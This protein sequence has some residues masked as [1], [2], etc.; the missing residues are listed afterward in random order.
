MRIAFFAD[1]PDQHDEP[2]LAVDVV[3]QS[4]QA[5]RADRAEHGERHAEQDDERQQ[6]A[7]VLRRERQVDEQQAEPEDDDRPACP[8]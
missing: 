3:G 4:A 1:K 8:P 6:E 2:D 7:L 5:L